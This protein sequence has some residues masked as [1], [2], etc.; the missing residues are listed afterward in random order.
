MQPDNHIKIAGVKWETK[1]E[2]E[3]SNHSHDHQHKHGHHH[4][5]SKSNNTRRIFLRIVHSNS[6]LPIPIL[7]MVLATYML[8]GNFNFDYFYL[9]FLS[10]STLLLYP[11]HRLIGVKMTIPVEF[12]KAQRGVSN[13]PQITYTAII[14]GFIGTAF[15]A[16]QL[17]FE[18]IELL[19]PLGII[20]IG[21][22]IPF[23]PTSN[24]WKRL[25]D[26]PGI[27][28]YAI[29]LVVTL[30]TSTIPL[31][32]IGS[33]SSTDIILLGIQRFLFILAI[34]IPFDIRDVV[35]D[36]KWKL[37]TIPLILGNEKAIKLAIVLINLTLIIAL[38]QFFFTHLL[39]FEI[40][41]A[42]LISNLWIS[43]VLSIFKENNTPLFNAFIVE[44]T[45]VFYFAMVTL[46]S[47]VITL[48]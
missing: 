9:G 17:S 18:T 11:L 32:L 36:K 20:S 43:Y 26:I 47:I 1:P 45:M 5:H 19:L 22:S 39:G 27:K 7:A 3:K 40:L 2:K 34:T 16:S 13:H 29:S 35:M 6:Y 21:Y 37:K 14:I 10:F 24:G 12:T 30:T 33:L 46:A 48:F 31:L 28:I 4:H 38:A 8:L 41:I 44:G 15:F 25:R 23:I 42:I